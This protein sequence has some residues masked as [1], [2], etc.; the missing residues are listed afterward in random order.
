MR[1][2]KFRAWDNYLKVMH[3]DVHRLD[4]FNEYLSKEKFDCLQ[5][6]GLKDKNGKEIYEGDIVRTWTN[7]HGEPTEP[8]FKSH[9]R[10]NEDVGC[11]Q[12]A[13]KNI[14]DKE[15]WDNIGFSYFL[16]VIGNIHE[17]PDL[18]K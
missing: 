13:Y 11:W 3:H 15:V 2:I 8:M 12:I 6:T 4:S 5:F 9:V 17:N 18:L 10:Y 1:E 7:Y 16:E 14:N